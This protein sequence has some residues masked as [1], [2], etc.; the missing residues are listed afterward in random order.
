MPV[1]HVDVPVGD[2]H[3]DQL[4]AGAREDV[5]LHVES[6]RATLAEA[7]GDRTAT[8]VCIATALVRD[9]E[10]MPRK[11]LAAMLATALVQMAETKEVTP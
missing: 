7:A 9:V 11:R 4:A 5:A 1:H 10:N 3:N 2:A 8:V 6:A